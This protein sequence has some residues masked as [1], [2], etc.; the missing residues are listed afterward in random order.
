MIHTT[1]LRNSL[2][3]KVIICVGM[4]LGVATTTGCGSNSATIPDALPIV[5]AALPST[6]KSSAASFMM[7]ANGL[8]SDDFHA[9]NANVDELKSRLFSS[10]PTDFQYRLKM[11]DSRLNGFESSAGDCVKKT[12]QAWSVPVGSTGIPLTTMYFQCY[13]TATADGVS[14]YK[15]YFGKQDGYWYLAE[16]QVNS[17]FEAGDGE[18]PTMGVL[19]KIADDSSSVEAYQISVEKSSGTYY[20]T[21]TQILANKT[22]GVFEV[23]SASSANSTQVVTPGAN[24]TGLG[25]GVQMK[26]DGTNVYGTGSFSQAVTCASSASPCVAASDLSTTGTCTSLQTLGTVAM[27]R[28][29]LISASAGT[30]AKAIVVDRTGI[31][32][33][34]ELKSDN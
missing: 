5:Q 10:G 28:T 19:S 25:C 6:L 17:S 1:L 20:S 12:A 3:F 14:D 18:P 26:T 2:K 13:T 27:T 21:I 33:V 4:L 29:G 9:L 16:L 8:S 34:D 32:S 30:V 31:P 11:I 22:T 23:S 7:R 15:I 24:Y